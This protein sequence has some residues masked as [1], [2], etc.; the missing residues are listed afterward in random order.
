QR[1]KTLSAS[2][3]EPLPRG[4]HIGALDLSPAV[5]AFTLVSEGALLFVAAQTGFLDGP[6]TL[7]A[8]AVDEWVPK[9]FK[10]LSERLVTQNGIITMGLAAIAVLLY[11]HGVVAILVVMYSINVFLTF[12]L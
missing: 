2:L 9:R 3:W 4:W 7:S 10:N 8:M 1:R 5:V 12:T 11:T 6:R